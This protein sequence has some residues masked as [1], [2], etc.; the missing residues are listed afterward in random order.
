MQSMW[1][2]YEKYLRDR[3]AVTQRD[4]VF[5]RSTR[6]NKRIGHRLLICTMRDK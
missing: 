4:E 6:K 2:I 3:T 5:L 1:I